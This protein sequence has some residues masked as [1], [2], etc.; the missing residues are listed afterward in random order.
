QEPGLRRPGVGGARDLA[1]AGRDLRADRA[2]Q[3]RHTQDRD[4]RPPA[5]HLARLV[6]RR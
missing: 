3:P 2:A 4:L 5:Q 6:H 1:Q